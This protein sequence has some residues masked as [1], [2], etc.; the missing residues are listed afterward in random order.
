MFPRSPILTVLLPAALLAGCGTSNRGLESVHQPVVERTDYVFDV[1]TAGYGLAPGEAERLAGWLASLR[2]GYGDIVALDDPAGGGARGEV[3]AAAARYG[4]LLADT[5][6]ITAGAVTPGTARVIVSRARAF[7]PGCPDFSRTYQPNYNAH[8]SSNQGCASNSNLAAMV[9][10]PTDLIR[11]VPGSDTLDP[12][13]GVKA[14]DAYRKAA[15]SG[16]GGTVVKTESTGG[17]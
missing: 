13:S 7:V 17:K 9:A 8:T 15:P 16:G 5:A 11:G 14:V 1:A 10:N 6:P 2:V 3:Q 12:A 4:L